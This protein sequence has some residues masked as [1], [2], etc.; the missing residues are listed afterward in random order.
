MIELYTVSGSP[1]SWR[2]ILTA[3]VKG[4]PY[5]PHVLQLSKGEHRSPEYL[6]MNPRGREPLLKD[7][8]FVV[9]ESLA[10]MIY[11]DRQSDRT[12]LFGTDTTSTVRIFEGLSQV[13]FDCEK[14]TLLLAE[15][16]LYRSANAD[17]SEAIRKAGEKLRGELKIMDER[18]GRQP[19]LVG[20][21]ISAAD[22]AALPLIM[23]IARAAGKDV[24]KDLDLGLIPLDTHFPHVAA[25]VKRMEA[26]PGYERAFPAHWREG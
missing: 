12:P 10:M 16:T 3:E 9:T 24:A 15:P 6:K 17:P 13:L 21:A 2:V 23:T 22:V 4:V 18:L 11:I 20:E 25:W 14:A 26:L 7:G 1:Y 8:D 5:Q 19:W